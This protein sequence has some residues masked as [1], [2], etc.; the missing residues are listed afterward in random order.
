MRTLVQ[1]FPPLATITARQQQQQQE[2]TIRTIRVRMVPSEVLVRQRQRLLPLPPKVVRE[3][4]PKPANT[5]FRL[6]CFSFLFLEWPHNDF[7]IF[8]VFFWYKSYLDLLMGDDD[9]CMRFNA[10]EKS[11]IF[12]HAL[13]LSIVFFLECSSCS[14]ERKSSHP[15]Y[16]GRKGFDHVIVKYAPDSVLCVEMRYDGDR[17]LY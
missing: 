8:L 2:H 9:D 12:L 4:G 16:S 5:A 15:M 13:F 7:D 1:C 6:P 11:I 17:L 3:Q 14:L 10:W